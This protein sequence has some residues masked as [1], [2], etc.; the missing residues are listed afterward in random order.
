MRRVR[1]AA[2]EAHLP[3][4]IH[5]GRSYT[6]LKEFLAL[7]K[8]GDILTHVYNPRS[9]SISDSARAL[10]PEVLEARKRGVLFDVGHGRTNFSFQVAERCL[11]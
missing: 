3:L 4:M 7:M 2:D 9:N 5:V 10:L 1:A 6:P 11:G 8:E